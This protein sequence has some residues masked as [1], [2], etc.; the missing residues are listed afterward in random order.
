MFDQR[1]ASALAAWP[2]ARA[3]V[4]DEDATPARIVSYGELRG[5]VARS[6]AQLTA[7]GVGPG[8]LVPLLTRQSPEAVAV[9]CALLLEG[10]AFCFLSERFSADDRRW[11]VDRMDPVG[12]IVDAHGA[13]LLRDASADDIAAFRPIRLD[14][15]GLY[16]PGPPRTGSAAFHDVAHAHFSSGSTG[17]PK[18]VLGSREGLSHFADVQIDGSAITEADRLLCIVSFASNLGLVQIFTALFT[19]ASLHLSRARGRALGDVIR[20]AGITGLGGSTPMWTS[21]LA[22]GGPAEPLFGD[23]PSLRY[24]F[25]GGLHMPRSRFRQLFERLGAH[26]AVY[27]I[28]GQAEVRQMTHFPINAPEHKE[29]MESVGRSV[30]G[31]ALFVAADERT[32]AA[33]GAIGEIAHT[34]PGIMVG[35]LGEPELT[36]ATLRTH[37]QFPGR[38]VVYTGDLGYQDEDGYVYL[39]GRAS[40]MIETAGAT[41]WPTEIENALAACP[42]VTDAV[43]AGVVVGGETVVAAAVVAEGA[44]P[45]RLRARVAELLPEHAIPAHIAVWPQLPTTPNG[46]PAIARITT[47]LA[48]ELDSAQ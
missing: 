31:S 23:V 6:R 27:E 3:A 36:A 29:R 19:G 10:A 1:L 48:A 33:P 37:G 21:A 30:E 46:K 17:R 38:P 24:I 47:D 14:A 40:R 28:Y 4:V 26:V 18:A 20:R 7:L 41:V 16:A 15:D 9:A 44:D 25:T 34:G 39:K 11:L 35:Y 42:G 8:H 12:L 13:E 32:V 5:M 22:A 45:A 43:A 2:D